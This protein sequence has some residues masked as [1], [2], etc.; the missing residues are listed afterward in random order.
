MPYKHNSN[1]TLGISRML[2]VLERAFR[3]LASKPKLF[4][5]RIVTTSAYSAFLL[6]T[7]GKTYELVSTGTTNLLPLLAFLPLLLLMDVLTYGMYASLA[8]QVQRSGEVSLRRALREALLQ[9]R[10][11]VIIGASFLGMVFLLSLSVAM[12]LA[13]Y[14]LLRI[15]LMLPAAALLMLTGMVALGY[16]FFYTVPVAV[17]ERGGFMQVMRRSVQLSQRHRGEVLLLNV[18]MLVLAVASLVVGMLTGFRGEAF[19]MSALLYMAGRGVQAVIYT[20]LS[21]ISP[22]AYLREDVRGG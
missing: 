9:W 18:L 14:V 6:L 17:M 22:A 19:L 10:C 3:M 15:Q 16:L 8:A 1:S 2:E 11:L 13:G 7:A 21:L 4:V 12:L 20:Y 5:P